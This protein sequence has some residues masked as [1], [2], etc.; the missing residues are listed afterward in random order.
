M[1]FWGR[2]RTL[3]APVPPPQLARWLVERQS[4]MPEDL[5][6]HLVLPLAWAAFRFVPERSAFARVQVPLMVV[7]MQRD[8]FTVEKF[9]ESLEHFG[10]DEAELSRLVA[11]PASTLELE[12]VE[13]LERRR[14]GREGVVDLAVQAVGEH[15]GLADGVMAERGL[16]EGT[17]SRHWAA[18]DEAMAAGQPVRGLARACAED[19]LESDESRARAWALWARRTDD[20][21]EAIE[22]FRRSLALLADPDVVCELADARMF[23]LPEGPGPHDGPWSA[24]ADEIVAT[25]SRALEQGTTSPALAYRAIAE[26]RLSQGRLADSLRAYEFLLAHKPDRHPNVRIGRIARQG[27]LVRLGRVEEA[28]ELCS[29]DL[30]PSGR[31]R[32]GDLIRKTYLQLRLGRLDEALVTAEEAVAEEKGHMALAARGHVQAL[33]GH[34]DAAKADFDAFLSS[35]D[36]VDEHPFARVRRAWV[37]EALKAWEPAIIDLTQAMSDGG[38]NQIE[39]ELRS[40]AHG[41]PPDRGTR[42][43]FEAW[44]RELLA[45]LLP[46]IDHP[47]VAAWRDR[48]VSSEAQLHAVLAELTEAMVDDDRTL[49]RAVA[50]VGPAWYRALAGDPSFL[51]VRARLRRYL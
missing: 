29:A 45:E 7:L 33:R 46:A 37:S 25:A 15:L 47:R 5:R 12:I 51:E 21:H 38:W 14:G 30:E 31:S 22:G 39:V 34:W 1:S 10:G 32:R 50:A 11:A 19:P 35:D 40:Y 48:L 2:L 6:A 28:L 41:L 27:L 36:I 43:G 3:A 16:V 20:S 8:E 18:I 17:E 26:A 24:E 4:A 44:R 9:V 42:A 13:G 49:R 23:L